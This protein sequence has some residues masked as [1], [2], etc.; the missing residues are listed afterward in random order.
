M[1]SVIML[2]FANNPSMLSFVMQNVVM[3]SVMAPLNLLCRQVGPLCN[4]LE[5]LYNLDASALV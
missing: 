2:N 3:M 4:K 5:R 1:P